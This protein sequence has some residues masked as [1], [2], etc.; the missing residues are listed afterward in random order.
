MNKK[1]HW[2][3]TRYE[4]SI[5]THKRDPI[6]RQIKLKIL[7][8][9]EY[10]SAL[11]LTFKFSNSN[12]TTCRRKQYFHSGSLHRKT[13][14]LRFGRLNF[15]QNNILHIIIQSCVCVYVG[16]QEIRMWVWNV[17]IS[18]CESRDLLKVDKSDRSV[19]FGNVINVIRRILPGLWLIIL[20]DLSWLITLSFWCPKRG[21]Y[22]EKNFF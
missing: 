12:F 19:A 14:S 7:K 17:E 11:R 16:K 1:A 9:N 13:A 5:Y 15:S 21:R 10:L 22:C 3:R 4:I 18:Y 2:Y 6:G 8:E 20:F